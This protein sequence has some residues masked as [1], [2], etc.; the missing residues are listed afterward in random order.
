MTTRTEATQELA[1]AKRA[2]VTARRHFER[3]AGRLEGATRPR[4]IR[5][6]E[7]RVAAAR[8]T[9]TEAR[10]TTQRERGELRDVTASWSEFARQA[11]LLF[12]WMTPALAREYATN[13]MAEDSS[14]LALA[15]TRESELYQRMFP[16]IR[17]DNG[18][19]R[20][21]E[22]EY[23]ATVESYEDTLADVQVNPRFFSDLLVQAIEGNVSTLEFKQRINA[24]EERINQAGR[25][26]VDAYS[27]Y[28]GTDGATT[29]K[30]ML[31]MALDPTIGQAVL[32]RRIAVAEIGGQAAVQGFT[33]N[34]ILANQMRQAGID[35]GGAQELF[36]QAAEILP[37]VSGALRRSNEGRFGIGEFIKAQGLQDAGQRA[38]L[39][40][41]IAGE[42]SRFTEQGG[43]ATDQ[44][45]RQ[46]GLRQR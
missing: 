22:E 4:A 33:I 5:K 6:L 38:R 40:R 20:M 11:A 14:E 30:A 12:P 1:A 42:Q 2:Q 36:G 29:R 17:R 46:T 9:L 18:S 19:L 21:T 45:G 35:S 41:G 39:Q 25:Q 37:G 16:G 27:A 24:I 3:L 32:E 31:A 13:W 26:F 23:M 15:V 44:A 34:R 8:S 10:E 43:T 7:S 28:F